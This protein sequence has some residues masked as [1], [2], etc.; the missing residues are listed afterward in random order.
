[1]KPRNRPTSRT[2]PVN[3]QPLRLFVRVAELSTISAAARE[4]NVSPSFATRKIAALERAFDARLFERTTRSVKLTEPG[5]IALRWARQTLDAYEEVQDSVTSVLNQP[6]G[7]IRLAVNHYVASVHLATALTQ[8]CADYPKI[9]ILITTTDSIVHLV[10]DGYDLAIHSGSLPDS[11]VVGVRVREFR[12]VICASPAYLAR[13]GTPGHPGDLGEHDCL[14]HSAKEP[15]N[16]FFQRGRRIIAQP[17]RPYIEADTNMLLVDLARAGLGIVRMGYEVVADDIA[18]KR[19]VEL[20]TD[21]KC[22]YSNGELPGL[23]LVYPNRRVLYRTR[24]LIDF[25]TKQLARK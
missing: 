3:L 11:S 8:F 2:T 13:R 9:Q 25:L 17:I 1:M 12:R 10:Q 5:Q 18:A 7:T 16:W 23:W 21:Y 20:M 15:S 22:V 14:V 4:L 24:V 6:S 19:L